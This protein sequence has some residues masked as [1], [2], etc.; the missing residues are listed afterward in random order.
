VYTAVV[1]TIKLKGDRRLKQWLK[2]VEAKHPSLSYFVK[3]RIITDNLYGVDIMEEANERTLVSTIIPPAIDVDN[4]ASVVVLSETGASLISYHE[5]L[6]ICSVFNSF[7]LDYSVRQ[8][9][10]TNLNFFYIYQLPVPRLVEDDRFFNEIVQRAAK[11]I[12][13]TPEFN[14]LAQ[15]VAAQSFAP[16]HSHKDGITDETQ[17]AQLRA[18]LDGMIAH[19]YDLTEDEFQHILSTFPIVPEATKQAALEAYKTFTL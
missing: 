9:V 8:R 17:R 15:E 19:L 5:Q 3:K 10:T 18:E 4:L 12:C 16:L 2:D 1:G 6:F 13:T 14:D 7:V 11:L